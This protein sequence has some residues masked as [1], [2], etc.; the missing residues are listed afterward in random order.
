MRSG[1]AAG[2]SSLS[3][4]LESPGDFVD[5]KESEV[6][7]GY[8]AGCR[9]SGLYSFFDLGVV[10]GINESSEHARDRYSERA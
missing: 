9:L 8:Y 4:P 1:K 2:R 10:G 6:A 7:R 3:G 5:G